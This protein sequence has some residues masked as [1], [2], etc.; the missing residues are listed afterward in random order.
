MPSAPL[1]S[2]WHVPSFAT[3]VPP[4]PPQPAKVSIEGSKPTTPTSDATPKKSPPKI[5]HTGNENDKYFST[6]SASTILSP[7]SAITEVTEAGPSCSPSNMKRPVQQRMIG[8]ER[9]MEEPGDEPLSNSFETLNTIDM[10]N[11]NFVHQCKSAKDLGKII[12]LLAD[13]SGSPQL[14]QT[15][16]LRLQ[17]VQGKKAPPP[18]PRRPGPVKLVV[19][20]KPLSIDV[21]QSAPMESEKDDE[22]DDNKSP[23]KI[24]TDST[25]NISRITLGN[26]T[27]DSLDASKNSLN[28]SYSP[29]S[30]LRG[31][32]LVETPNHSRSALY[33]ESR[34][35]R[36]GTISEISVSNQVTPQSDTE[37]ERLSEEVKKLSLDAVEMESMRAEENSAFVM[38]LNAL[39]SAKRKAETLVK[40]LESQV[41]VASVEK[42]DAI[43]AMEKIQQQQQAMREALQQER[44]RLQERDAETR[45]LEQR[46]QGK[47]A[48]L[49]N[50][51][52]QEV[53]RSN[54]VISAERSL[55]LKHESDLELQRERNVELNQ[56]LRQT[57]EN[58]ERIKRTQDLFR[59]ELLKAFGEKEDEVSLFDVL[60]HDWYM[61]P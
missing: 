5:I 53:E 14:L 20:S 2:Q 17:L 49:Q 16:R 4:P 59:A 7:I 46:M 61:K 27:I 50:A 48:E 55:R 24:F 60:M 35:T 19:S 9:T 21:Q 51:M 32:S 56:L 22:Y 30:I 10:L 8:L 37:Q 40:T 39:Q 23:G 58:L 15:A 28:L 26:T 45:A 18:P 54:L 47:I 29:S 1:Q 6:Q 41:T 13:K 57:K 3:K 38:K 12:R 11:F 36:L 42:D 31:L 43:K 44:A 25:A 33:S 34:Y 52:Q